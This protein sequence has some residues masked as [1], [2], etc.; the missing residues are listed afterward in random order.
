MPAPESSPLDSMERTH[1]STQ[2]WQSFEVRMRQRRIERCL[3]RAALALDEGRPDDAREP[4]EEVRRLEPSSPDLAALELRL[5]QLPPQLT[6]A[7]GLIVRLAES[8]YLVASA[9]PDAQALTAPEPAAQDNR[10]SHGRASMFLAAAAVVAIA[11]WAA[12]PAG[13][14]PQSHPLAN[15]VARALDSVPVAPA[16][17]PDAVHDDKPDS[18]KVEVM[19][20]KAEAIVAR[21]VP[22]PVE[23][24]ANGTSVAPARVEPEATAAAGDAALPAAAAAAMTPPPAETV[25]ALDL[26]VPTEGTVP[27]VDAPTPKDPPVDHGA[28]VRAVLARYE[29]AYSRLDASAARA[30]WPSVDERALARAFGGLQAQRLSLGRCEVSVSGATARADCSG[31]A[32]WTPKVG[33][34]GRTQERR[35]R[36]DLNNAGGAWQISRAEAR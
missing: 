31:S 8:D 13:V 24:E 26:P 10:P 21:T 7:A 17:V 32:T 30:V 9:E 5:T 20:L 2:Q 11:A 33:G 12:W 18:V 4:L 3:L 35:W 16:S 34:G 15:P 1:T 23:P 28:L 14:A 6:P 22:R 29:A 36:F 27:R 25:T 19:E